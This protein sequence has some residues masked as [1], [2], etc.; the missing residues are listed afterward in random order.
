MT[1]RKIF[2]ADFSV[3]VAEQIS[4]ISAS[5]IF[6][7]RF[8]AAKKFQNGFFGQILHLGGLRPMSRPMYVQCTSNA[9][10]LYPLYFPIRPM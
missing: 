4:E 9:N 7:T 3:A 10:S 5:E 2:A 8:H 6:S 1:S